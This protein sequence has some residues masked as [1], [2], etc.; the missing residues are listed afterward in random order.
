MT[1]STQKLSSTASRKRGTPTP[2]PA[3][4]MKVLPLGNE[5]VQ[6][7]LDVP[8]SERDAAKNLR[9]RFDS[10]TKLWYVPHGLD[11]FPFFRWR[12]DLKDPFAR[13]KTKELRRQGKRKKTKGL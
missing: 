3:R 7:Y 4:P 8:A 5:R 10:P 12:K 1:N 11:I 9:A 6:L 2:A 13:D